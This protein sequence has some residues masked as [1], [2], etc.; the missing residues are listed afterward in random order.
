MT[1]KSFCV[2]S[3]FK[4]KFWSGALSDIWAL[5]TLY[6]SSEMNLHCL[7]LLLSIQMS[8]Q[9]NISIDSK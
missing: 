9:F 1:T 3:S 2:F 7:V 5:L 8:I 4:E 6:F